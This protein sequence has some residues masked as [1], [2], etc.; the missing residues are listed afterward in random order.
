M[1]RIL[2]M[3]QSW[4][5]PGRS[6]TSSQI[7]RQ[8]W[9]KWERKEEVR[10]QLKKHIKRALLILE[11][12][13]GRNRDESNDFILDMAKRI[14]TPPFRFSVCKIACD[15]CGRKFNSL[16]VARPKTQRILYLC[17]FCYQQWQKGARAV[18]WQGQRG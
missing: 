8:D 2:L 15:G 10:N 12:V 16:F 9:I 3:A 13:L 14:T 18:P 7:V 11:R 6:K 1:F 5:Y 4:S 17:P